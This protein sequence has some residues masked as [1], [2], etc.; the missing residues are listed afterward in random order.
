MNKRIKGKNFKYLIHAL[1]EKEI[2][3]AIF[4]YMENR[5]KMKVNRRG[6]VKFEKYQSWKRTKKFKLNRPQIIASVKIKNIY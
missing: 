1:V 4:D 5:T 6:G 3:T 2:K